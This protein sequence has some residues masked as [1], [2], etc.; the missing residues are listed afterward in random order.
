VALQPSRP[1]LRFPRKQ[2]FQAFGTA[3][4]KHFA[5]TWERLMAIDLNG[6]RVVINGAGQGIGAA[7]AR[8]VADRAPVW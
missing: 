8:G 5:N 6:V 7:I 1:S 3:L 4:A 2:R